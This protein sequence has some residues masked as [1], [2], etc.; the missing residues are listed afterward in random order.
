MITKIYFH[1]TR[2]D[3]YELNDLLEELGSYENT[4]KIRGLGYE[5][6]MTIE[7]DKNCNVKVL[8]IG[9]TDVSDKNISV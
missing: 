2:E 6:E 1:R 4:D 7:I 9:N 3:N 5:V 8:K